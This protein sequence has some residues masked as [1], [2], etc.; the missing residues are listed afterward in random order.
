[1]IH[2][3]LP[4]ISF[5]TERPPSIWVDEAIWGHR[6]YDEQT[7]WLIF[8]E[9]LNVLLSDDMA[10]RAFKEVSGFNALS[11]SPKRFLHSRNIV[12]N[13]PKIKKILT[14]YPND[15]TRWQKWISEMG[16]NRRSGVDTGFLFVRSRFTTFEEFSWVVELLRSSS[17]EGNSNK[18]FTSKFVFPYG[19]DCL[20]EDLDERSFAPGRRFFGRTGELAYLMLCRSGRGDEIIEKLRPIV[21]DRG[22]P[23]NRLVKSLHPEED[24][25]HESH[26]HAYLPYADLPDYKALAGDWITLVSC[27]MPGYDVLPHLVTILGLHML[28]YFLKRGREH[29]EGKSD[30]QLICEIIAPRKTVVRDLSVESYQANNLYSIDAIRQYIESIA[31]STE[32]KNA[33]SDGDRRQKVAEILKETFWWEPEG[34]QEPEEMLASLKEDAKSRH[35]QHTAKIHS[36]WTRSLGI[37]S[38]RGTRSVRYAPTDSFLK[39]LVFT[40][41]SVRMEFQ[42]FLQE[43]YSRYGFIIGHHQ[44]EVASLIGSK[45][46]DLQAFKENAQ[47]LEMRLVSLGLVRRLS[48]ACAYVINPYTS[49]VR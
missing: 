40:V 39:S 48:D 17:I 12:F 16:G 18:Q 29:S 21:F 44:A 11:Y 19:P 33:L 32:W 24:S 8:L 49:N 1:M 5:G 13:N 25:L 23:L 20:Y 22:K 46:G 3:K 30:I 41:V 9:F 42:L 15:E 35:G 6:L 34:L 26:K 47:R 7:P 4:K 37:A 38:R 28:L 31:E 43:I 14:D 36:N 27:G 2:P 10:G 45:K